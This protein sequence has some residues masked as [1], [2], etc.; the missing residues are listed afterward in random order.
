MNSEAMRFC[1]AQRAAA[2]A[3]AKNRPLTSVPEAQMVQAQLQ[4]PRKE[5]SVPNPK[6]SQES[7]MMDS[8]DKVP[9]LRRMSGQAFISSEEKVSCAW[10][11]LVSVKL[12][13]TQVADLVLLCM[14]QTKC[15][16]IEAM[17][18]PFATSI[19]MQSWRGTS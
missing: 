10:P 12:P 3:A 6:V 13:A 16:A 11:A 5:P 7:E 15:S 2:A 9:K 8:E 19:A 1:A 17:M 4:E 18:Q 14:M